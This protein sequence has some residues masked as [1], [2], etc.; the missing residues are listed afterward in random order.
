MEG[1]AFVLRPDISKE[2]KPRQLAPG[3]LGGPLKDPLGTYASEAGL[4]MR[5]SALTPYTMYALEA[6][7]HAQQQGKFDVFHLAAYK[8]YWED[9]KDLGDLGVIEEL[10]VASGLDWPELAERLESGY[11][12]DTILAQ[13]RE[14]IDLGIRGIPAFLIGNQMFTGAQP[15]EVFELAH[16]RAGETIAPGDPK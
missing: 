2:G 3:E 13:Y 8:A 9:G 14:A 10:T 6:T 12:R 4:V 15:Y 1:R 7:E 5:R 11:Y 16:A